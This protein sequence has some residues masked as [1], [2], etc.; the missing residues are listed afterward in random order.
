MAGIRVLSAAAVRQGLTAL[1]DRFGA[2]TGS[3][4]SLAFATGPNIRDRLESEADVA[5]LIVAPDGL[6]DSLAGK[7]RVRGDSAAK[8]GGVEAG[9]AVKAGAPAPDISTAASLAASASKR[10]GAGLKGCPVRSASWAIT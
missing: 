5:D 9:V 7:G 1:T 2:E 4:V 6:I 3:E 10:L 8:L